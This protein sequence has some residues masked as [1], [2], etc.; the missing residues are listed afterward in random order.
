L[1]FLGAQPSRATQKQVQAVESPVARNRRGAMR[2]SQWIDIFKQVLER[3][4]DLEVEGP[5]GFLL[6]KV[7]VIT[8]TRQSAEDRQRPT[9]IPQPPAGGNK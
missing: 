1:E 5:D 9:Q 8:R 4:G 7:Q 3:E 2:L 6:K